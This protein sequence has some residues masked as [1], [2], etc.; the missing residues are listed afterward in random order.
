MPSIGLFSI[1][2]RPSRRPSESIEDLPKRI[3]RATPRT[4]RIDASIPLP[5]QKTM[6]ALLLVFIPQRG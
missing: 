3:D 2:H 5:V 4:Y 6:E 1:E